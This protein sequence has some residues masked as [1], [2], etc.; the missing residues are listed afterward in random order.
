VDLETIVLKAMAREAGSR[1][2]TARELADDL[3]R[4]CDSRPILARRPSLIESTSKWIKRHSALVASAVISMLLLS[5][6]LIVSTVLIAQEQLRTQDALVEVQSRQK[7]TERALLAEAEQ[8]RLAEENFQQAREM[9]DFFLNTTEEKLA[10][11]REFYEIRSEL[12]VASLN[13]YQDFIVKAENN[14]PLQ[15]QLA[16]SHQRVARIL[17][18]I[19]F[20]SAA[21]T[22]LENALLTQERLVQENPR[23]RDLRRGLFGLYVELGSFRGN[24]P[25]YLAG[26][27]RVHEELKM[28]EEQ[29][30]TATQIA[31]DYRNLYRPAWFSYEPT[32]MRKRFRTGTESALH[33]VRELLT[34]EQYDRLMQIAL[35]HRGIHAWHDPSVAETLQLSDLQRIE[36]RTISDRQW[37]DLN[38]R[39]H[40]DSKVHEGCMD[41]E[42]RMYAV[43]SEAQVD[44][45]ETMTGTPFD[46]RID[47]WQWHNGGRSKGKHKDSQH[48]D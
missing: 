20:N 33:D 37:Q 11:H 46:G 8:R 28:T 34:D 45:W 30:E 15:A 14:R 36:L 22:A 16:S 4:F 21:E 35:Q 18:R 42:S 7:D 1:Y 6:G 44:R 3:R 29:V 17:H 31:M 47:F 24:G 38:R 5:C 13:Y 27:S 23:D 39:G 43:L 19:G 25:I 40:K 41:Y 26:D 10:D 48:S 2:S 12:L 32:E 9:L